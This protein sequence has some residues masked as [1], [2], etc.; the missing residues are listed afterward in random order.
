M[1]PPGGAPVPGNDLRDLW[2]YFVS[3]GC[4]LRRHRSGLK[5]V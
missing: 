5:T 2:C 3:G 1:S 4:F